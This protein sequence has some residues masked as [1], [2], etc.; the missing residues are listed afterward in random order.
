MKVYEVQFYNDNNERGSE[1]IK[2]VKSIS[3][4][5]MAGEQINDN[6]AAYAYWRSNI[7]KY[8]I[9]RNFADESLHDL[10]EKTLVWSSYE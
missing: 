9:Y 3:P 5:E 2:S 1:G 10:K 8:K 4:S 7:D 6:F